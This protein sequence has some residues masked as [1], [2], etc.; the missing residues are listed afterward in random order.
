MRCGWWSKRQPSSP[1]MKP[2]RATR[3]AKP[4]TGAYGLE[5]AYAEAVDRH[6]MEKAT[7]ADREAIG[8]VVQAF[9]LPPGAAASIHYVIGQLRQTRADVGGPPYSDGERA[10]ALARVGELAD[11]LARAL[12]RVEATPSDREALALQ[13]ARQSALQMLD[14]VTPDGPYTGLPSTF[15]NALLVLPE[16]ARAVKTEIPGGGK[17]G[18]RPRSTNRYLD[19]F[20]D[21][22]LVGFPAGLRPCTKPFDK[23]CAAVWAVA[24]QGE[25]PGHESSL[26][27]F[28]KDRWPALERRIDAGDFGPLPIGWQ[29]PG[30]RQATAKP[31]TPKEVAARNLEQ[32]WGKPPG[33]QAG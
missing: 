3:P 7:A 30:R 2:E 19:I 31:P 8:A 14:T 9:E 18:G 25:P 20:H 26:K 22:A 5:R 32:G 17:S 10:K 1:A 6:F 21:L 33:K 11:Q 13:F 27:A 24:M 4:V 16:A 15:W 28:M 29:R 23:F 12:I